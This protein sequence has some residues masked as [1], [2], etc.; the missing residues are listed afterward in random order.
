[1]MDFAAN[2]SSGSRRTSIKDNI[3]LKN[4]H[5]CCSSMCGGGADNNDDGMQDGT[6]GYKVVE[7]DLRGP[8]AFSR[9][10]GSKM[11][12]VVMRALDKGHHSRC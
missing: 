4:S 5:G 9:T 1:M 11:Q 6:K 2:S 7:E 8:E 12:H 10:L 3:V